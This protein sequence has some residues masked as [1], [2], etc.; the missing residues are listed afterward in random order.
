MQ[1]AGFS[2]ALLV[3]SESETETDEEMYGP[4][5]RRKGSTGKLESPACERPEASLLM[6]TSLSCIDCVE[7]A[8]LPH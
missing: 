4:A 5:K 1:A 7:E 6:Q 3:R 2:Q 8:V